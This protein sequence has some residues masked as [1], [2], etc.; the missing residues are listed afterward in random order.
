MKR[1]RRAERLKYRQIKAIET[2]AANKVVKVKERQ[3]RDARMLAKLQG[4]SLPYTPDVMS[5]LSCQIGKKS[6]R[7]NDDDV[8]NLLARRS[9]AAR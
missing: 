9:A 6:S 4:A 8:K 3:R 1:S 7:I 5:W 2:K